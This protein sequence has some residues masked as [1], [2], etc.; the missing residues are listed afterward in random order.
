[1]AIGALDFDKWSDTEY[2]MEKHQRGFAYHEYRMA[3][4]GLKNPA[5][6]G[7]LALGPDS[8]PVFSSPVWKPTIEQ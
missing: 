3:I 1:M 4:A 7:G 5:N 2:G 6:E 8:W